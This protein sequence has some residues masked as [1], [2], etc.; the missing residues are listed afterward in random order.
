MLPGHHAPVCGIAQGV[1]VLRGGLAPELLHQS[2]AHLFVAEDIV[3]GHAGLAAVEE[4]AVHYAPGRQ[5]DIG[6]IIHYDRALAAQLQ[7]HAREVLRRRAQHLAAYFRPAGEENLV[8][9]LAQQG[10]V[11]LPAP[12][13]AAHVVFRKYRAEQPRYY[14][15]RRR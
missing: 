13:D 15:A 3:R 2:G 9:A 1:R 11:L 10:G 12:G 8:P 7:R 4:F 5:T 6:R 14:R